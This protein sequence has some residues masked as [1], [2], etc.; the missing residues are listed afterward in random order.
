M[1]RWWRLWLRP[2]QVQRRAGRLHADLG[3]GRARGQGDSLVNS[4]VSPKLAWAYRLVTCERGQYVGQGNGHRENN[5][6]FGGG[7][8][9]ATSRDSRGR[10]YVRRR[11]PRDLEYYDASELSALWPVVELSFGHHRAAL[12]S[13]MPRAAA[14]GGRVRPPGR[15]GRSGGQMASGRG[16]DGP[17]RG[18]RGRDGRTRRATAI[19]P[20]G[21]GRGPIVTTPDL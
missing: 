17:G 8:Q 13:P 10:G 4:V 16:A 9:L 5:Q 14:R 11:R 15:V 20:C 19:H 12:L 3:A 7:G 1:R 21:L 2:R 18:C 6:T